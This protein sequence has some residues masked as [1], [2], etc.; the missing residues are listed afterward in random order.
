MI[1]LKNAKEP[2]FKPL[3]GEDSMNAR[4]L[5]SQ[6]CATLATTAVAY[7]ADVLHSHPN[8]PHD[9]LPKKRSFGI[10]ITKDV[11]YCDHRHLII[12]AVQNSRKLS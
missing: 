10:L 6:R 4:N 5:L 9:K 12:L 3:F 1:S 7:V 11:Y 8:S 2:I